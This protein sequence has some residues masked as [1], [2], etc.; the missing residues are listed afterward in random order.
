MI[1]NIKLKINIIIKNKYKIMNLPLVP[2]NLT[3]DPS[4]YQSEVPFKSD[5]NIYQQVAENINTLT[6]LDNKELTDTNTID[7]I[8]ELDIKNNDE[9]NII[10][11]PFK[12]ITGIRISYSI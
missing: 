11:Y 1:K 12:N 7:D 6:Y 2:Y 4:I 9:N 8:I 10:T 3:F 5:I